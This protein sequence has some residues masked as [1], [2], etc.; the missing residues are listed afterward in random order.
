MFFL[1][2][3]SSSSSC[4]WLHQRWLWT[5]HPA[6]RSK[7]QG[8]ST[9]STNRTEW[10]SWLP[11]CGTCSRYHQGLQPDSAPSHGES[12][13]VMGKETITF[14]AKASM[15]WRMPVTFLHWHPTCT[16]CSLPRSASKT[17]TWTVSRLLAL[18]CA[19]LLTILCH[20]GSIG[21]FW[22]AYSCL[23]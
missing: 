20:S 1:Q 21:V 16:L 19:A 2:T 6:Q 8:S 10:S 11:R 3:V 14:K 7:Q 9:L 18:S 15:R 23:W 12:L 4:F 5:R 13:V 17:R 22:V